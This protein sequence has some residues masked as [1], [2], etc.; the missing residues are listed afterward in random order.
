MST[1]SLLVYMPEIVTSK[2]QPVPTRGRLAAGGGSSSLARLLRVWL[3][4]LGRPS[5]EADR[6]SRVTQIVRSPHRID[7]CFTIWRM[8]M[9][10]TSTALVCD[11]VLEDQS[12]L[13]G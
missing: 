11:D 13:I 4:E 12:C 1:L 9:V 10:R 8:L 7:N 3:E 5:V 2:H 6:A